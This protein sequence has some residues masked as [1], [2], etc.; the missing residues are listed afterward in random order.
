MLFFLLWFEDRLALP[1]WLQVVG[2]MHPLLLHFPL[3]LI[4]LY[5]LLVIVLPKDEV[6]QKLSS[7]ILLFAALTAVITAIMGLFLSREEGYDREALMWHKWGGVGVSVFSLIW[8]WV[9]H[10]VRG[11]KLLTVTTSV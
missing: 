5:A 4:I 3:V 6:Y 8:Y 2:R 7:S 11:K 1:A 9:Q 10:S